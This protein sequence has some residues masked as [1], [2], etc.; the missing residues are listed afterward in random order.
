MEDSQVPRPF[1]GD[2]DGSEDGR[3]PD[4][5]T[6]ACDGLRS[7][8]TVQSQ[9]PYKTV[10]FLIKQ[11]GPTY[12]RVKF[13]IQDSQVPRPFAGDDDGSEDGRLPDLCVVARRPCDH[14]HTHSLFRTLSH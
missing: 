8:K 3:L 4:L 9:G 14:T 13:H 2:D 5:R 1:A 6:V 10:K 11:S 7:F 12:K